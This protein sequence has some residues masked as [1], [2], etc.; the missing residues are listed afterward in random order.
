MQTARLVARNWTRSESYFASAARFYPISNLY[1][2]F[3]GMSFDCCYLISTMRCPK[4]F[5]VIR[6]CSLLL[7]MGI[8]TMGSAQ[9]E[10]KKYLDSLYR[11]DSLKYGPYKAVKKDTVAGERKPEVLKLSQTDSFKV[12]AEKRFQAVRDN[13]DAPYLGLYLCKADWVSEQFK[14]ENGMD[15]GFP[16]TLTMHYTSHGFFFEANADA[17]Y[18]M[19]REMIFYGLSTPSNQRFKRF[20][21]ANQF[22]YANI[23]GMLPLQNSHKSRIGPGIFWGGFDNEYG[24]VQQIFGGS[25]CYRYTTKNHYP[26]I[27]QGKYGAGVI[28]IARNR[29]KLMGRFW[30]ISA[31]FPIAFSKNSDAVFQISPYALY[32]NI[33][34]YENHVFRFNFSTFMV[35]VRFG[36]GFKDVNL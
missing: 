18:R 11:A 12:A 17:F 3:I 2:A 24:Y 33:P 28:D 4:C 21:A 5:P 1:C 15:N 36:V 23:G 35:G 8:F 10:L 7:T 22:I 6:F 34:Y 13:N 29:T 14:V 19:W 26:L 30:E 32:S 25:A 20:N 16:L 31:H 9:T 27:L